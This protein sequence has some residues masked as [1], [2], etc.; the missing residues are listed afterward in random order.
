M[1]KVIFQ[2]YKEVFS[3]VLWCKFWEKLLATAELEEKSLVKFPW[4]NSRGWLPTIFLKIQHSRGRLKDH[5]KCLLHI[6]DTGKKRLAQDRSGYLMVKPEK[7]ASQDFYILSE[8]QNF[9]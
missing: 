3:L 1:K 6:Q 4:Q 9:Q 5:D 8:C 7:K 2:Y